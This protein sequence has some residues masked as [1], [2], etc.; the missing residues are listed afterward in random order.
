[1]TRYGGSGNVKSVVTSLM[2]SLQPDKTLTPELSS[3]QNKEKQE[4]QLQKFRLQG[5]II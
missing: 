3:K 5:I 4:I 2:V 1:M